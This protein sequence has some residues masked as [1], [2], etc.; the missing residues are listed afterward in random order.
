MQSSI[1]VSCRHHAILSLLQDC[2]Y[3]S[4][5]ELAKVLNVS[6][7]TIRRDL[8]MLES[9]HQLRRCHGGAEAL[10]KQS[11]REH[12]P[13]TEQAITIAK[14]IVTELEA[15]SCL[16]IDS[17][18]VGAAV[19][20]LLP[21]EVYYLI[22]QHIELIGIARRNPFIAIFF[23]GRELS[24]GDADVSI[25]MSMI[26]WLPRPVDYSIVEVDYIDNSGIIFGDCFKY[27]SV[28]R[29]FLRGGQRQYVVYRQDDC[30]RRSLV[31]L[32]AMDRH[33]RV[34]CLA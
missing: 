11:S 3:I 8:N 13:E 34:F 7:H 25:Q 24:P 9:Q 20:G 29:H 5:D 32:G 22:T 26:K 28:K 30:T 33:K 19:V 6:V 12:A 17:Q 18:T 14:A 27:P 16:Y 21:E 31:K 1:Q 15:G 10:N 2:G 4:T 23:L